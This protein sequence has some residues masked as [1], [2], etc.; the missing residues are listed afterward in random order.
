MFPKMNTYVDGEISRAIIV[1]QD[2]SVDTKEYAA[3]LSTLEKLQKIRQEEKPDSFSSDALLMAV[4]NLLGILAILKHEQLNV[5]TT[6]ALTF[7]QR[8][9]S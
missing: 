4:T 3:A 1:L 9:R 5:I 7:V 6:K 2:L 8:T